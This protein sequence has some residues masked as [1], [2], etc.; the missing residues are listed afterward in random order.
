[1]YA[2]KIQFNT[3]LYKIGGFTCHDAI[4]VV[5]NAFQSA[6]NVVDTVSE[7]AMNRFNAEESVLHLK[8]KEKYERPLKDEE[9]INVSDFVDIEGNEDVDVFNFFDIEK[10]E[11]KEIS[12]EEEVE[13]PQINP[14]LREALKT[15]GD[16]YRARYFE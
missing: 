5:T 2:T 1:M 16:L 14:K 9:E 11:D 15:N 4:E 12:L 3:F 13:I 6:Q 8:F 7:E 10:K